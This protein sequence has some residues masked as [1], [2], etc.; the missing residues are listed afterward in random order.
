MA[1]SAITALQVTR[2]LKSDLGVAT[3]DLRKYHPDSYQRVQF[4]VDSVAASMKLGDEDA[5]LLEGALIRLMHF[6]ATQSSEAAIRSTNRLRRKAATDLKASAEKKP[7]A[8]RKSRQKP[9]GANEVD[10]PL[11][12]VQ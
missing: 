4:A 12:V 6:E 11:P 3:F 5:S 9:N 10:A 1:S 2:I 7:R 8:S